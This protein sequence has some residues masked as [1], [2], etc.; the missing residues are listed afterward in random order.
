LIERL[1][2]VV[3]VSIAVQAVV[4]VVVVAATPVGAMVVALAVP[5]N[6]S[7]ALVHAFETRVTAQ[8]VRRSIAIICYFDPSVKS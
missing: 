4:Q 2:V 8:T 1:V 5:P 3:V 7:L 6:P